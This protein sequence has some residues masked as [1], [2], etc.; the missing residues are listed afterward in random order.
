MKKLIASALFCLTALGVSSV[1]ATPIQWDSG[2]GA[3]SH[4]YD[5]V[6]LEPVLDWEVAAAEAVTKGGYLASITSEE[7]NTFV[8][9]L[10]AADRDPARYWLGG[11]QSDNSGGAEWKWHNGDPWGYTNWYQPHEPNNALVNGQYQN[12]LH[13]WPVN[14]QWDDMEN[15]RYMAGYVIEMDSAP[16]PEPATILLLG[17]GFAGL[18]GARLRRRKR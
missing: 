2:A 13:F 12:Y 14:G 4:W 10:L 15:G 6:L 18:A 16:V 8:A 1:S 11:Y 17:A 5:I 7:E 3:N 9:G